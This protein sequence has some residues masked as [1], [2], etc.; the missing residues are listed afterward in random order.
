MS[1]KSG[2][3]QRLE[4]SK[5]ESPAFPIEKQLIFQGLSPPVTPSLGIQAPH[6]LDFGLFCFGVLFC[7]LGKLLQLLGCKLERGRHSAGLSA[8]AVTHPQF[9]LS[10]E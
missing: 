9:L 7:L 1:N 10:P 2:V 3:P 5:D 4:V 6:L 8:R